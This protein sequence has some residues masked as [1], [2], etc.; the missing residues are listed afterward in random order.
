MS[1]ISVVIPTRDRAPLLQRTLRC[2]LGQTGVEIEVIVVDD[3]SVDGTP[4]MLESVHD[5]RLIVERRREPEGVSAA[6]NAGIARAT[7][8][9]VAFLDDDDLWAP[10][11]LARQLV[12]AEASG[13]SW[14]Y[15]GAVAVDEELRIVAGS[16]PP[17][18][19]DVVTAVPM[20][21]SVVAGSSNVL[22]RRDVLAE[23]GGFD[24]ALRHMADWDLWIRL[25][26][27]GA[28]AAVSEPLVA[29]LLHAGNASLDQEGI[30]AEMS[31]IEQRYRQ[32]RGSANVDRPY[33]YRWA[34]WSALR[35][36]RRL[37][38]MSGYARAVGSGDWRSL[39]RLL[40]AALRPSFATGRYGRR[41][42]DAG[43]AAAADTWLAGYR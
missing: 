40:V 39:G 23:S 25:A 29:Y 8:E 27:L 20:R 5:P 43:W 6:R 18:P 12:A 3:G 28:P 42:P 35:S 26:A 33:V 1:L 2:A 17:S 4:A 36:G 31:V 16:P 10:T 11:K 30:Y 32:E 38:A 24:E 7:G 9:W 34:A 41:L 19:D 37:A 13:R 15:S 21:N 14:C 22:V